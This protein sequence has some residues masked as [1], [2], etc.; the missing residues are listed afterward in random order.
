[1]L[2]LL[3]NT[4]AS[5]VADD[6]H[7]HCN[8]H[9]L[10]VLSV[11]LENADPLRE[12]DHPLERLQIIVPTG[13][14]VRATTKH[15]ARAY[16][17]RFDLPAPAPQLSTLEEFV[18]DYAQSFE[19][20]RSKRLM[21]DALRFAL[22]R[23]AIQNC[24][25]TRRLVFHSPNGQP[26][27]LS[28]CERLAELIYG[29][30]RKGIG[31]EELDRDIALAESEQN[32]T[33]VYL[34]RL[35]DIRTIYAAYL[36]CMGSQLLDMPAL[37]ELLQS[38]IEGS[39]S[40]PLAQK[41]EART[42]LVEGFS[43]FTLPELKLL[44][45]IASSHHALV[46]VL[47]LDPNNK[48]LFANA[49]EAERHLIDAGMMHRGKSNLASDDSPTL[50][51]SLW[52]QSQLFAQA[53]MM[54]SETRDLPST[55]AP[56][57]SLG[58][59]Q[60]NET[61]QTS[62]PR[63]APDFSS[64]V[65][66]IACPT[67][68]DEVRVI[69]KAIRHALSVEGIAAHEIA[70][71]NR[72]PQTYSSLI[73]EVFD[74]H[75]IPLNMSDRFRLDTSPIIV[76]IFHMIDVVLRG[77]QRDDLIRALS[78]PSMQAFCETRAIIPIDVEH[79]A[80][81]LR[82]FGGLRNGSAE[83]WRESLQRS[84]DATLRQHELMKNDPATDLR[85][86]KQHS[87]FCREIEQ[88]LHDVELLASILPQRDSR[89]TVRG[90]AKTFSS[91]FV[92]KLEIHRGVDR[93]ARAAFSE[94][95]KAYSTHHDAS[96][97]FDHYTHL[98][99]NTRA[100]QTLMR[101]LDELESVLLERGMTL[102]RFVDFAELLRSSVRGA[103]YQ[104]RER[105]GLGVRVTS[106]E[107]TRGIP[108]RRL[109]L[110]GVV[111]RQFPLAYTPEYLLGQEFPD[112]EQRHSVAER[113]NFYHAL[114]NN[115]A[116][117]DDASMRIVVSYPALNANMEEE[118]ESNFLH[119][120]LRCA[121]S[122]KQHSLKQIRQLMRRDPMN[123]ELDWCRDWIQA[124]VTDDEILRAE[125]VASV[126]ETSS[127]HAHLADRAQHRRRVR[128]N[129]LLQIAG[130][131]ELRAS[132]NERGFDTRAALMPQPISTSDLDTYAKCAYKYFA[133]R[134]LSV[135]VDQEEEA[136]LSPMDLGN[137]LHHVVH[138]FYL[139]LSQNNLAMHESIQ[140]QRG[141]LRMIRLQ[142][143][144]REQYEELLRSIAEDELSRMQFDHPFF[145]LTRDE[146]LGM[147]Q[148]EG[149]LHTWLEEELQRS[150]YWQHAATLFEYDFGYARKA[151]ARSGI[152]LDGLQI[153]GKIDRV[154]LRARG[155]GSYEVLIADYKTRPSGIS[156]NKDII[157]G[158]SFQIPLYLAA[159]QKAI[160]EDFG[161]ETHPA[162]GVYYIFKTD[163]RSHQFVMLSLDSDLVSDERYELSKRSTKQILA[164]DRSTED[165]IL[166]SLEQAIRIVEAG[167]S[168]EFPVKPLPGACQYCEFVSL[169]RIREIERLG[170]GDEIGAP[171]E[172]D[173]QSD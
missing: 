119:E 5:A 20:L 94:L 63:T 78:H 73:R 2:H 79:A 70:V 138:R 53:E 90:L 163:E 36:D 21:S 66:I 14:L 17:D 164:D 61:S 123:S 135:G 98:E 137:L 171:A 58:F 101:L 3:Y 43:E 59:E 132:M 65:R 96:L 113:L 152:D 108:Y 91:L 54:N 15:F 75:D 115:P 147:G 139:E 26:V 62:T 172:E 95:H 141:K 19:S 112:A 97:D 168:G 160:E 82:L 72:Q 31:L 143:Q 149:L 158:H 24:V 47:H 7:R 27:P 81:R 60:L 136:A 148:N 110:C 100:L 103:K 109:F 28:M 120:L 157:E 134:T 11:L 18:L 6:V 125:S 51:A 68:R 154:E 167:N 161:I 35:R 76:S 4:R 74:A 48:A 129:F 87:E 12:A 116:A 52:L 144:R 127:R 13:R 99:Q 111:D 118:V 151:G 22:F 105:S 92:E 29:I 145:Q 159:V 1:M 45:A 83:G 126:D 133:K 102:I 122:V 117:L 146:L 170:P 131:R 55:N 57:L 38:E 30:R 107:Q 10:D 50:S 33:M 56:Q 140:S 71:V 150:E 64:S 130:A 80:M 42:I 142:E 155:D 85:D 162:A 128:E 153:R 9:G 106:I 34:D 23:E 165:T 69:A 124:L 88:A 37:Q 169:C 156:S 46:V 104:I 166:E 41:T 84:H 93:D 32:S 77:W 39:A 173:N 40:A 49:L 86:L 25:E 114:N 16:F 121:P 8:P 89:W 44:G 67:M